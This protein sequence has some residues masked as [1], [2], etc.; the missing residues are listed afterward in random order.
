MTN[1]GVTV[2]LPHDKMCLLAGSNRQAAQ[3][4]HSQLVK[5][6]LKSNLL[7]NDIIAQRLQE[8]Y[9]GNARGT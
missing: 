2:H 8:E 7:L 9:K 4:D 6:N 1:S 3:P 5:K